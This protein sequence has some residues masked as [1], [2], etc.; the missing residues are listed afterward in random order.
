MEMK[1]VCAG[2]KAAPYGD[3]VGRLLALRESQS[4]EASAADQLLMLRD[5]ALARPNGIFLELG[6][7][8]GQAT[9]V[10]LNALSGAP[11]KLVSVDIEDCRHAGEGPNWQ[12]VQCDSKDATA[13]V[14]EAPV[15]AQ[16]IDLVYVD[17]LH[18]VAQV[19][20]EIN[21]WFPYVKP[22]GQIVFDDV[23]PV[24]YMFGHRKDSARKEMTNRALG[25]LVS[26]LF[27]DNLDSLRMEM[28]MGSTGL[29]IWTK[30]SGLGAGLRPYQP[31]TAQ[32]TNRALADLHDE[33][34]GHTEYKH[35]DANGA[36]MIPLER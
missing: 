14:A 30:T 9:K 19:H 25:Q 24:P 7:W 35:R 16:G 4:E 32:R 18:T 33:V 28:K 10:M 15:L 27:Y 13:I 22:G 26:D 20:A 2:E 34:R 21:A 31:L 1:Q 8:H 29:A 17:G 23:D 5:A 3:Y 12:F 6:T 36:T 11:G